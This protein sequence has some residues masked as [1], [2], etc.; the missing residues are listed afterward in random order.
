MAHTTA[1][2]RLIR[3]GMQSLTDTSVLTRERK[4]WRNGPKGHLHA[5][6]GCYKFTGGHV[7]NSV[8]LSFVEASGKR[9]CNSCWEPR[10]LGTP[11][12][13]VLSAL[14]ETED[15]LQ[16]A[17]AHIDGK[18]SISDSGAAIVNLRIARS[19]LARL[20][21]DERDMV[22]Q[23]AKQLGERIDML[24]GRLREK[25][26]AA[27]TMLPN[28]A[29]A[30][31]L[32]QI[33]SGGPGTVPGADVTDQ[34]VYGETPNTRGDAH[35]IT[36]FHAWCS[37]RRSG[38]DKALESARVRVAEAQLTNPGQLRFDLRAPLG[39]GDLYE[40][41][42][43]TW[44]QETE[45]RLVER[46]VPAWEAAYQELLTKQDQ[47]VVGITSQSFQQDES[48]T[49]IDSYPHAAGRH[50]ETIL[51]VPQVLAMWLEKFE[52]R[53]SID[54]HYVKCDLDTELLD[55]V[56][57]LWTPKDIGSEFRELQ[58]A[59]DAAGNL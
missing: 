24:A 43:A 59:I 27:K 37:R 49:I 18:R 26:G 7:D 13:T 5:E 57:T 16:Q 31:L 9:Q 40:S 56:A 1:L 30:S 41:A 23:A 20:K 47:C 52:N 6:A 12:A 50:G 48:R 28:W 10:A 22:E 38:E 4:F 8:V 54:T 46:L 39:E 14:L 35:I 32:R 29:A 11:Y 36:V 34:R 45:L 53:W 42:V 58:A 17:E 25:V 44:R 15:Q 19:A 33:A 55:T 21:E 3:L 2:T 51:K